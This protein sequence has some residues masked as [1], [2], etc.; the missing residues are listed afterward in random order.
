MKDGDMNSK[1]FH[2]CANQRRKKNE[3][4]KLV[5]DDGKMINDMHGIVE[6]F[7]QH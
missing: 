5:L 2:R 6:A 3:I 7:C 4:T 1:Y